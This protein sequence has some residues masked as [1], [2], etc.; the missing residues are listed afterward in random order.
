[1]HL[2][3][4]TSSGFFFLAP[5]LVFAPLAGL[6]INMIFA[7]RFKFS[8]NLIG[9]IASAAS[10]VAFIVSILLTYSL[11]LQHGEAAR[12]RLAE[13]FSIGSLSLDWTFRMDTLS[14]TMMLVVSGVGTLIH[15]YA[16]GY[17]REDVRFKHEEG[18]FA[19]FFIFLNLFLASML[20]LVS[21]DSYLMLFVGWE[22]VGFCS[23]LLIG[24]WFEMDTLGR[25]SWANSN[26]AKKAFI[27]NRVGDFGFLIA[28]FLIFWNLGQSLQ[29]DQVF[30]AAKNAPPGV[31]VAITL[32]LL[33]GVAGKSAQIPLYIWLPDAMAGPTP[34]SALMHAATMVTA[35][36]YLVTRSAPF[37]NLVPDA[38]YI[39]AMV[40]AITALFA[41]TIAVGQYDI[42]KVLAYS[43]ISQLGFMVAAV[44][45][46]AYVAGFF[47]LIAHAFFKALLFLS[48]GSIILGIERGHHHA[49]HAEHADKSKSKKGKKEEHGHAEHGEEA[50]DPG[51]MRNMGGMRKTMP[52]TFW[53]YLIGALALSGIFPFAGFWSKDEILLDA[54]L[55][56]PAAYWLLTIAAFF[57]AFYMGRQ[58]WMVFFGE[59]RTAPAK[60]AQESPKVMTLPLVAL[61]ILSVGGGA[62]NFPF[63]GFH[64]LG[65]WLEHTLGEVESMPLNLQ[66]AG[67]STLLAL[68]AIGISWL[69][70]GR[71]P[72]QNGEPD[73]LKKA[74]G[75]IYTGMENKWFVDEGYAALVIKPFDKLSQ[76]LADVVDWRFWHDFVHERLI[77]GTYNWISAIALDKYSDKQGIDAFANGLA[78]V[79]Q[80][81]SAGMRKIQNGF[82]RSYALSILLGVVLILSYLI[83]K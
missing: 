6:L 13:W 14:T 67:V 34:V 42:K 73:P 33:L 54:K 59:A 61:A 63:E 36:V 57:T 43:T 24:F 83:F 17:M 44:G 4:I 49:E 31:I 51:D 40:G 72:L 81:L 5:W 77:A 16:I 80:R 56:Y 74:L 9:G 1:M 82:V 23:F 18:R 26:A 45:M 37:Y 79:S 11:S 48:A 27:A 3:E 25:S 30:E 69:I 47:H 55:H 2:S 50:F 66:V 70:Y 32:F 21:G 68:I 78:T 7:N 10:G 60:H 38:Q 64:N 8:E 28:S 52:V 19:R 22:G 41:A 29:F 35:G 53:M 76:F 39:V 65:H 20:V 58:I 71:K 12:W 62:L 15:I 75:F 46:G